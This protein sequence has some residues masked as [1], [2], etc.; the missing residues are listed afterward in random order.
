MFNFGGG[1]GSLGRFIPIF[2]IFFFINVFMQLA[3]GGLDDILNTLLPMAET[4]D[5]TETAM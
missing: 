5:M 3:S 4:M 1:G 2:I